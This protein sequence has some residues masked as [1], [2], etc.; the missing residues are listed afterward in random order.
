MLSLFAKI[1]LDKRNLFINPDNEN[2]IKLKK[3]EK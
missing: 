2:I 1:E 3:L